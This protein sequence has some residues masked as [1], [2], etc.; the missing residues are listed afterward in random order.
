MPVFLGTVGAAVITCVGAVVVA[1][2]FVMLVMLS[3]ATVDMAVSSGAI[4][5]DSF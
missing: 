1:F 5:V 3:S 4:T 2:V